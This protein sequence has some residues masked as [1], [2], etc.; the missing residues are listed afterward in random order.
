MADERPVPERPV[1]DRP[2]AEGGGFSGGAA[3]DNHGM[4]WVALVLLLVM[5][6]VVGWRLYDFWDSRQ[7]PS[8]V[9][10]QQATVLGFEDLG[11][12]RAGQRSTEYTSVVFELPD[13]EQASALYELRRLGDVGKGDEITVYQ[14]GGEWRTTAERAWG[15]TLGW[16]L[17]LVALLAM[18]V[19]WF[20]VRSRAKR[21]ESPA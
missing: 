20:R 21:R 9:Q 4:T 10:T 17:G 3:R 19:G 16:A 13:G 12:S 6:V 1:P 2:G 18:V 11:P 15:S 8:S 7:P 14:Q 5:V